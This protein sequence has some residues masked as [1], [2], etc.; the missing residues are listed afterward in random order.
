MGK[1]RFSLTNIILWGVL[2]LFCFLS[3]NYALFSNNPKSG[4]NTQSTLLLTICILLVLVFY[5]F[6]EHKNNRVSFDKVLLPCF[7]VFGFLM[8]LNIFRQSDRTLMSLDGTNEIVFSISMTDKLTASSQVLIWLS[9][10]Y[11]LIFVSNRFRLKD[12][13]FRLIAK[14]YVIFILLSIVAD[15]FYEFHTINE[16][17]NSPWYQK[18]F[19]F[20]FG[21]GNVW[22]LLVL[23][24]ILSA[25]VL[26]VRKFYLPYYISMLVMAVY[27]ILTKSSACIL[28][29]AAVVFAYSLYEI[30]VLFKHNRKRAVQMLIV[31]SSIVVFAITMLIIVTNVNPIS[32]TRIGS[33]I[34]GLFLGKKLDSI[35]GRTNIWKGVIN[36]VKGNTLDMLFGLGHVTGSNLFK[37]VAYDGY[38]YYGGLKS[39]HNAFLEILLRY[40]MLGLFVYISLLLL[41]VYCLALHIKAKNYRFAFLYGLVYLALLLHSVVESTTIFTPNVEGLYFGFIFILPILKILQK[42]RFDELKSNTISME[43]EKGEIHVNVI[44]VLLIYF[45]VSV[46]VTKI[47][48]NFTNITVFDFFALL[49]T[50]FLIGFVF[51]DK[52]TGDQINHRILYLNRNNIVKEKKNE[53]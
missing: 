38:S 44:V 16:V 1:L 14:L 25:V 51:I 11:G 4:L 36:I 37:L 33:F 41:I 13:I 21:N 49:I 28:I 48:A 6:L 47:V 15:L 53:E 3:E 9:I 45:V 50:E 42:K 20:I 30:I 32:N 12:G 31:L 2:I 10:I 35:S 8:I 34:K 29:G 23:T 19:C 43:I 17:L 26:S 27:L 40:G 18:G 24:G 46:V 52:H 5:F 39:T 7:M 22:A